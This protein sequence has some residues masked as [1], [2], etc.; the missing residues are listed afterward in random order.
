MGEQFEFRFAREKKKRDAALDLLQEYRAG[1][2]AR[3]K[4]IAFSLASR[5]GKVTS[6]E[7]VA[8]LREE[9][10]KGINQVDMRFMG[11]VF[12][13]GWK[14]IGFTPRGSHC[15]PISVWEIK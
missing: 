9:K 12:R 4:E 15:Q 8:V 7:V 1:L 5:N 13:S 14:R 11:C 2:I 10:F 3:A 6:P